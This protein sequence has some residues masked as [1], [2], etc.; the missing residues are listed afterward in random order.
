M[1][2]SEKTKFL[3]SNL[4]RGLVW[5]IVIVALFLYVGSLIDEAHIEEYLQPIYDKP[6]W[7]FV[8]FALSE[9]VFGII[10]PEFFMIWSARS[11]DIGFYVT[12]IFVLSILSYGAGVIGYLIGNYLHNTSLY[13]YIHTRYL[14]K[15]I[16]YFQQFG[17][18]LIIVA[19]LTPLPFSAIAMLMGAV[20]FTYKKYLLYS[21]FRFARF[22]VY[23]ILIWNAH[24]II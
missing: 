24:V 16:R 4:I 11:T 6:F 21:L 12:T 13:K 2:L 10:P 23:S 20:R 1:P 3:L 5:L 8:V 18:F 7:V 19:T 17:G 14:E 9:I 15:Y 22:T